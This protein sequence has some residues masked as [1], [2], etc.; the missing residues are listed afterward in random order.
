MELENEN[1]K[2]KSKI[3]RLEQEKNEAIFETKKAKLRIEELERSLEIAR[4]QID[5]SQK[6]GGEQ[7]TMSQVDITEPLP[8]VPEKRDKSPFKELKR[9]KMPSE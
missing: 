7:H 3:N 4:Q 2:L 1:H 8:V 9:V 5:Q 6:E